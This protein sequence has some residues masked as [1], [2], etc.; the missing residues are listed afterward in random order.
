MSGMNL[1]KKE[2]NTFYGLVSFPSLND[3]SLAEVLGE[4]MSTVTS[5]RRRLRDRGFYH[6]IRVPRFR[7]LSCEI[8]CIVH[9]SFKPVAPQGSDALCKVSEKIP[10]SFF[11]MCNP[12]HFIILGVARSYTEARITYD[13]Y[14]TN[15]KFLKAVDEKDLTFSYLPYEMTEIHNF[16]DF[17]PLMKKV[18]G[19]SKDHEEPSTPDPGLKEVSLTPT[20]KK[21]FLGLIEYPE[22]ADK[23]LAERIKVSR[24]AVS[25]MRKRFETDGLL[26]TAIIPNL[27]KLDLGMIIFTHY[28]L[29]PKKAGRFDNKAMPAQKDAL[30]SFFSCSTRFE[31]F[32]LSAFKSYQE[33]ERM[34]ERYF[35][36]Y[37]EKKVLLSSPTMIPFS[38][39]DVA[40]FRNHTY[41]NILQNL[42]SL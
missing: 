9:G 32:G 26:R 3:R 34:S 18:F 27:A 13:N 36:L 16:F 39:A 15:P 19:I 1:T 38:I 4:K 25:K 33:Y 29:N 28:T 12:Y 8:L 30:P 31:H 17:G 41:S 21:V 7:S 37:N 11:G 2:R 42:L 10:I 22:L 40:Y 14:Y 6:K 20:E 5:I 35:K 23:N 24:Q